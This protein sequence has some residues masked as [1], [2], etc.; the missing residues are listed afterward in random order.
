VSVNFRALALHEST[1]AVIA[2]I[3]GARVDR[4]TIRPDDTQHP[5]EVTFKPYTRRPGIKEAEDRIVSNLAAGIAVKR[6]GGGW[7]GCEGDWHDAAEDAVLV[8]GT[9]DEAA[10]KLVLDRLALRAAALVQQ[11]GDAI[12]T[13]AVL[14]M[15]HHSLSGK[16]VAE[17]CNPKLTAFT[18][19]VAT[20][21]HID[22]VISERRA[23]VAQLRE[24]HETRYPRPVARE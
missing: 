19:A 8:A 21:R 7:D 14:L 15:E 13:A 1:H 4:V 2:T 11:H 22:D 23:A 6:A 24:R 20:G 17:L 12:V 3:L 5:G 10:V 18:E 9:D 16:Q